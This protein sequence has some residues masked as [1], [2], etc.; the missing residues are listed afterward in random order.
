MQTRKGLNKKPH[1]DI[2]K[3]PTANLCTRQK[4]TQDK[5]GLQYPVRKI[6]RSFLSFLAAHVLE[7]CISLRRPEIADET[8]AETATDNIEIQ[9]AN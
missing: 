7:H 1:T 8:R 9:T 4:Y 3:I 2:V 5:I 6:N